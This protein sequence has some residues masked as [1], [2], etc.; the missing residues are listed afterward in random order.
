M[1]TEVC[2]AIVKR[3]IPEVRLFCPNQPLERLV[4]RVL[5]P[6]ADVVLEEV[7]DVKHP[8]HVDFELVEP[9]EDGAS[10]DSGIC[11]PLR[12]LE[13][14]GGT[15]EP[16]DA[17]SEHELDGSEQVTILRLNYLGHTCPLAL[18]RTW[19]EEVLDDVRAVDELLEGLDV[20]ARQLRLAG[21]EGSG[22]P[23]GTAERIW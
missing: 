23:C 2:R 11:P 16:K 10:P 9:S 13:A 5:L 15:F 21:A 22:S 4:E 1:N 7:Q 19:T 12:V 20:V 17:R 8:H 14:V 3:R 6:L 18:P